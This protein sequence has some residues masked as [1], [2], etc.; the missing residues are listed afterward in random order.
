MDDQSEWS[1]EMIDLV[2]EISDEVC[3]DAEELFEDDTESLHTYLGS[4]AFY[5][6]LMSEESP[7]DLEAETF[8][9]LVFK[10]FKR[11]LENDSYFRDQFMNHVRRTSP[12]D[13]SPKNIK[14]YFD[15]HR[16]IEYLVS[17][18]RDFVETESLFQL[19]IDDE[20]RYRY[21]MDMIEKALESDKQESFKIFCH[22]GN[23][24][25]FLTGV[26]PDWIQHRHEFK[27]RP[28]DL[29]SYREYGVTY[30]QRAAKHDMAERWELDD[31]LTK[32]HRGYD[33]ARG[34]LN[35]I[36]RELP[37]A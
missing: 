31:V 27:N 9:Y 14:N 23:Y 13:V 35:L 34:G 26:F 15:D 16:L 2:E 29:D 22:I 36:F 32:L 30:F 7:L 8:F 20:D 18:L 25:L 6:D 1:R 24:S 3:D 33:V 11:K 28:L 21:F 4:E 37:A 17:M 12:E 5:E 19:P 10:R